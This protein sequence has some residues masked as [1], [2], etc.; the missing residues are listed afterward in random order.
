MREFIKEFLKVL[1]IEKG[2]AKN[3]LQSYKRDLI[4]YHLFIQKKAKIRGY[5]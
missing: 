4:K 1:K 2:L 5:S 3:S